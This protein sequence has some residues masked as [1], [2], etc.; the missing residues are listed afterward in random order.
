MA[1]GYVVPERPDWTRPRLAPAGDTVAAVRWHEG[2]PNVWIGTSKSPMQLASDLRPWRLCDFHWSTDSRGLILELELGNPDQRVLAWLDLGDRTLTRL[3]PSPSTDA[4]YAGQDEGRK[5]TVLAAVRHASGGGYQLQAVLP[6]GAVVAEWKS[7]CG[8]ASNWLS[9]HTQAVATCVSGATSTWWHGRLAEPSWSPIAELSAEDAVMSRPLAFSADGQTLF[10]MSTVGRDT[11]A[12]IRMSPPSWTPQIVSADERFDV[13]SVLMA[14]DGSA[15]DLV[16]TTRPGSPQSALTSEAAADL[17]RL[18]HLAGGAPATIVG[19]NDSH[20]LAEVSLPVGGPAFV[21]FSRTTG[22]M[23]KPLARF[24][25]FAG[26]RMQPRDAFAFLARDGREVS[27]FITRPSGVPPWPVVLAIHDGPWSR[28]LAQMDP[29]AQALAAGGLCCV[30]VNYRGSRGFGKQ[31]RDAGDKQ[32]SLAMQTDL[33]DAI[34]SADVAELTDPGRVAAIGYGYGGYAA[35]MLAT[36]T[37]VQLAAVAAGSAPT[38]LVSYI[39]GL[40]SLGGYPGIEEAAR[41]GDPVADRD[42]LIRASPLHRVDDFHIPVLLFH[43]RQD[44]RVP[45]SQATMFAEAL[46][47]AGQD[48]QLT[49]YENEG[50]RYTRPQNIA[51]LRARTFAFLLQI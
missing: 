13:T 48:C 49:I 6:T 16:T 11:L 22:A 3:T 45:I 4:R 43:G 17:A 47:R 21:T 2:A 27:G 1:A 37:E 33:V 20:C 24:T 19:R 25:S 12:L 40:A 31:F 15:P 28:D 41:I 44:E 29:W 30:Q 26:V 36:Q 34:R 35:L 42:Q 39:S 18:A 9:T 8:P 38:D 7:P 23:S 5:P 46:R 50:H 14:P 10:A 51:D 32:W